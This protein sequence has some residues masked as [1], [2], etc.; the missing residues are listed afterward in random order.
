[1]DRCG[2]GRSCSPRPSSECLVPDPG[3][4]GEA[5]P[6]HSSLEGSELAYGVLLAIVVARCEFLHGALKV[7][8]TL[9]VECTVVRPLEHGLRGRNPIGVN[10]NR[11]R[12]VRR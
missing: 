6:I 3:F 12:A 8:G 2:T 1:M 10:L 5:L 7:T 4:G 11:P 9:L